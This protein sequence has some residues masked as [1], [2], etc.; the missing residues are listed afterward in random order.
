MFKLLTLIF[1]FIIGIIFTFAYFINDGKE[2]TFG[3][4]MRAGFSTLKTTLT[5]KLVNKIESHTS[6]PSFL[7]KEI[8]SDKE[9]LTQMIPHY[10]EDILVSK[11]LLSKTEDE[12]LKTFLKKLILDESAEIENMKNLYSK[13]YGEEYNPGLYKYTDM[14]PKL[15]FSVNS[16]LGKVYAGGMI[17]HHK[18]AIEMA[19]QLQSVTKNEDM[20]TLAARVI[21][22]QSKEVEE[23]KRLIIN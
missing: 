10:T 4:N 21:E 2:A 14:L 9:F 23:L 12:N 1:G 6:M 19:K 15:N 17:I 18:R 13:N 5:G 3:E 16:S 8:S 11:E 22:N 20:E 7:T